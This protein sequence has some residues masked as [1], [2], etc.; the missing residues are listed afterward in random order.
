[1]RAIVVDSP[2][3]LGCGFADIPEP[4][5]SDGQVLVA[6]THASLNRGDLNDARSGRVAPGAVLGFDVAGT[7]TQTDA[8]GHGPADGTRVVALAAGAIAERCASTRPRSH[9]FL[10][11]STPPPPCRSPVSPPSKPCAPPV[12]RQANACSSPAP[13]AALGT[14]QCSSPPT[15]A[16]M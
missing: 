15:P 7:V 1:M 3:R 5:L 10:R 4:S 2:T 14:S 12:W 8:N 13:Q 11:P 6:V 16:L 9:R